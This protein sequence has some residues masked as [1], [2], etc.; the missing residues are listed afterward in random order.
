ME[1]KLKNQLHEIL[2]IV[3]QTN[4]FNQRRRTKTGT[5]PTV[6]FNYSG[7]VNSL[8]ID[9]HADGW[10]TSQGPT[11]SWDLSFDEPISDIVIETIRREMEAALSDKKESDVLRR[12]IDTYEKELLQRKKNLNAMRKELKKMEREGK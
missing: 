1:E 11:K 5:L 3:I 4:G 9:L 2:D 7:H 8:S 6:F 10:T 12:D